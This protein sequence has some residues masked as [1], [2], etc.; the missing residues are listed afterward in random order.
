MA[1][2]T[3]TRITMRE[4]KQGRL[5]GSKTVSSADLS[6]HG[7]GLDLGFVSLS[8]QPCSLKQNYRSSARKRILV[9]PACGV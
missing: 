6:A 1:G 2:D 9:Y 8:P 3:G 7:R 5:C 4:K